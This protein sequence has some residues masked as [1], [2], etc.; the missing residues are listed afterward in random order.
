MKFSQ[1]KRL[2]PGDEVTIKATNEIVTIISMKQKSGCN[3]MIDAM[4]KD[5]FRTLYHDEVM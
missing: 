3:I 5:G 4:T 2:Q 1:A